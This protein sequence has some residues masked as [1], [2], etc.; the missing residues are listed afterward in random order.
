MPTILL[1]CL[2]PIK[3]SHIKDAINTSIYDLVDVS[4]G[5]D[6]IK[7]IEDRDV[8]L[9]IS[10][11]NIGSFDVWKLTRLIR[12][13]IF[14]I[15]KNIPIVL[16]TQVIPVNLTQ[17][18]TRDFGINNFFSYD[19]IDYLSTLIPQLLKDPDKHLSK[20]TALVIEDHSSNAQLIKRIL[21]TRFDVD[22]AADGE[23]GMALWEEKRHNIVLLD[24]MLPKLSGTGVLARIMSI[25][26]DQIVIMITAH[27]TSK[28]AQEMMLNGATDFV[29]KP[30]KAEELRLVCE[31]TFKRRDFVAWNKYYEQLR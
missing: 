29:S 1:I 23:K 2:D 27:G 16:L 3:L 20:P 24:V 11:I 25:D 7:I 17:I 9:I 22:L 8:D 5:A 26:P 21:Q 12:S 13:N 19:Q 30:F 28:M 31:L 10:D 15:K 18:T 14:K 4:S 6:A